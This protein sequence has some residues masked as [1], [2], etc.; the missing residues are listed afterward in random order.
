MLAKHP[1]IYMSEIKEPTFF[2]EDFQ[3]VK[4][5]EAYYS[6]FAPAQNQKYRGES[7]H[8]YFTDPAVAPQLKDLFPQAKFILILRNPA[9]RAYSLYKHMRRHN[10]EKIPTFEKA[11]EA[12]ASRMNDTF[13]KTNGQYYH[14]FLYFHSGKYG[15]QLQHY[16]NYFPR[17]QF[18]VLKYEDLKKQPESLPLNISSFLNIDPFK[19]API[20]KSNVGYELRNSFLERIINSR[21]IS[22]RIS[23]SIGLKSLLSSINHKNLTKINPK[24]R[25][26]LM[27][28]YTPDLQLLNKLSGVHLD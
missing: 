12:E 27:K 24:T 28:N 11:L 19:H 6:L 16:L 3:V 14:N 21:V 4:S 7:S 5:E 17:S 20:I 13:R 2:C 10:H 9:D 25:E 18:L 15:E 22:N 23:T 8:G 1:D 26:S